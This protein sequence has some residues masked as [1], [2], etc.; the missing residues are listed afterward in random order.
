LTRLGPV[1]TIN[2]LRPGKPKLFAL[3]A[4][5]AVLATAVAI[6]AVFA[7]SST[8][9][10]ASRVRVTVE[11]AFVGRP[12]PAGFLG[13]SMEYPDLEGYAGTS[14]H[15]LDPILVRLIRG[16]A[17]YGNPSLR[18]GGDT[19]DWTWSPIRAMARPNGIRYSISRRWLAVAKALSTA[20]GAHLLLGVNLEADSRRIADAEVRR[21]TSTFGRQSIA[22]FEIG[23]EPELYDSFAWY[24]LN[25]QPH[26]GRPRGYTFGD[27]MADFARIA[28]TMPHAPLAGPDI[29]GPAWIPYLGRFLSGER[30]VGVATLHR[31][32]LKRCRASVHLTIGELLANSASTGLANGLAR[33]AEIAHA[34]HVPLRIDE[35]NAVSCGGEAGVSNTFAAALWSIDALFSLARVGVDGV[36]IHTR[37]RTSGE[38]FTVARAHGHWRAVVHPE[39][40][41]L[42]LFAQAAPPGARLLKISGANLRAVRIWATDDAGTVRVALVNKSTADARTISLRLPATGAGTG[43]LERLQDRSAHSTSGASL[44]AGAPISPQNGSYVVRLPAASAALL[45]VP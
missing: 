3:A 9:D 21:F 29:G 16:L 20:T 17:P 12:V 11:R 6:G 4:P 7:R 15:A 41:G 24:V 43:S 27:F 14:G 1:I 2:L 22:G 30:R 25:H 13:L 36:N 37:P 18:F 19:T 5:V 31:Y 44:S 35:M 32:P 26:Y 34:H 38:L 39:Y 33:Y 28:S 8:S 10:A 40:Y 42:A 23:N 45:T